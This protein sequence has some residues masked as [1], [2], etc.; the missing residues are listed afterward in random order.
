MGANGS[1]TTE[2]GPQTFLSRLWTLS[3]PAWL[4]SLFPARVNVCAPTLGW[5]FPAS[6]DFLTRVGVAF[7]CFRENAKHHVS[8]QEARPPV[9][10]WLLIS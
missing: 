4:G 10:S 8:H 5:L 1:P 2:A 3:L 9:G 6:D 7:V